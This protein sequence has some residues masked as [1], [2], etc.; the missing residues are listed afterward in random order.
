MKQAARSA[1][2][3]LMIEAISFSEALVDFQQT[4]WDYIPEDGTLHDHCCENLLYFI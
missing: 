1:F 4:T 2:Q 3:T